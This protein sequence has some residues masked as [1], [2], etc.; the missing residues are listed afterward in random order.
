MNR[1]T[2]VLSS[3]ALAFGVGIAACSASNDGAVFNGDPGG[4]QGAGAGNGSGGGS[5]GT[6][7]TGTEIFNPTTTG[8]GTGGPTCDHAPGEDGDGDG[9]TGAEGDCNDCDPNTNPGAIEVIQTEPDAD[10]GL[11]QADDD[12]DGQV[13]END[14][15]CDDALALDDTN[16]MSGAKAIDLCQQATAGDGKW[17][18]LNA[19][20]VRANGQ[21]TS[22]SIQ[23][24]LQPSF[25]NNVNVQLGTRLLALSSGAARTASQPG[26]CGSNSC[27]ESGAGTPPPGFPQDSGACLGGT[28]IND[29]VGLELTIRAPTNATGFSYLF[30]F[31][32]FEYPEW[33]CTT[34]NDQ[35][36]ALVTP[37][38]AGANN[39]NISFDSQNNP[40][41][42]NIAFFDVCAGC[43]LGTAELAGTGFDGAWGDDAG[44]TSWLKTTAPV[45]GGQEFTIRFAIW[46]T[47]DQA[48]DSTVLLDAFEWIAN[49][50]TVS[51]GTDPVPDPK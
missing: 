8:T 9:W 23:V 40:V 1:S 29:D 47:G 41:S 38:P 20:Y 39:G 31:Y 11:V 16:P 5:T 19:Q 50:G 17:G 49:G 37:P 25:G 30:D 32:S 46:D 24:G 33:V 3:L 15:V 7:S 14:G 6:G 48:W 35:Y 26:A 4:S 44:A 34:F 36:I 12:C 21:P 27:Y 43:S 22:G 18:V 51:V 13:D 45:T 42:V 2:L 10:G 28:N